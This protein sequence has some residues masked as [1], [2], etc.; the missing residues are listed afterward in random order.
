M[1]WF[2]FLILH[3]FV[4]CSFVQNLIKQRNFSS[5]QYPIDLILYF[6]RIYLLQ[7]KKTLNSNKNFSCHKLRSGYWPLFAQVLIKQNSLEKYKFFWS[8]SVQLSRVHKTRLCLNFVSIILMQL[9]FF[10]CCSYV[11]FRLVLLHLEDRW[12]TYCDYVCVFLCC[13]YFVAFVDF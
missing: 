13:V 7:K 5:I 8:A 6:S 11:W 1:I 9:L 12:L 4:E 2:L 3:I 10:F